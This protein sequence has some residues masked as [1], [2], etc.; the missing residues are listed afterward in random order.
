MPEVR[1][2]HGPVPEGEDLHGLRDSRGVA[3]VTC[4]CSDTCP[5]VKA[6]SVLDSVILGHRIQRGLCQVCTLLYVNDPSTQ[7]KVRRLL[8]GEAALETLRGW[9]T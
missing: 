1:R 3:E 4:L 6:V 7:T 2:P 8:A 5:D 9:T